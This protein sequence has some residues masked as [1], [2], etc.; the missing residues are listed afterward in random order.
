VTASGP[1][2]PGKPKW[3]TECELLNRVNQ[4]A[5]AQREHEEMRRQG[6]APAEIPPLVEPQAPI[7]R[8]GEPAS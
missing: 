2:I 4:E 1:P 7:E 5:V 6:E 3:L 8:E